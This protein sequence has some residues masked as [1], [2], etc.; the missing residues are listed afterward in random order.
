ME[1]L[2]TIVD[3]VKKD[4]ADKGESAEVLRRAAAVF[5]QYLSSAGVLPSDPKARSYFF[6]DFATD[7]VQAVSGLNTVTKP[8]V[9]LLKRSV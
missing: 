4:C 3:T 2:K 6:E 1:D 8:D 7:I 9:T 5:D